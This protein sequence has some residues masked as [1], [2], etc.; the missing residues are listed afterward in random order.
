VKIRLMQ[1]GRRESGDLVHHTVKHFLSPHERDEWDRVPPPDAPTAGHFAATIP[2]VS[3]RAPSIGDPVDARWWARPWGDH[4]QRAHAEGYAP[5]YRALVE[6]LGPLP[7]ARWERQR[8]DR[9]AGDI[10][11]FRLVVSQ[12]T[13]G[14]TQVISAYYSSVFR[15]DD[16]PER[17][18][19][20]F[21]EFAERRDCPRGPDTGVMGEETK[22]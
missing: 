2:R 13:G 1:L 11:G 15:H 7:S 4:A 19:R 20:A 17:A 8:E 16:R 9:W 18:L 12:T 3:G 14:E 22:P 6:M 10:H 21:R 5:R